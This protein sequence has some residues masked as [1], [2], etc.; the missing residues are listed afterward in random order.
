MP[1]LGRRG[2]RT[3]RSRTSRCVA[4]VSSSPPSLSRSRRR[5]ACL[6]PSAT[7]LSSPRDAT[8]ADAHAVLAPD[9]PQANPDQALPDELAVPPAAPY[10]SVQRTIAELNLVCPRLS[11]SRLP[12]A[13]YAPGSSADSSSGLAAHRVAS[14]LAAQPLAGP[15]ST[16]GPAGAGQPP[17]PAVAAAAAVS[18]RPSSTSAGPSQPPA[19]RQRPPS[20]PA[21]AS[22]AIRK[23]PASAAPPGARQS[24]TPKSAAAGPPRRSSV[25]ARPPQ[26]AQPP[27]PPS[28]K[29]DT[30]PLPRRRPPS[31]RA[32]ARQRPC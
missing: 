28:L 24:A 22:P 3:R 32:Q 12:L 5:P 25:H 4:R 11:L 23:P 7:R 20:Q 31:A 14:Q 1:T 6:P 29:P 15:S 16:Q 17:S 30:R 19:S 9:A 13:S 27:P 2:S 18:G 26:S 8:R 10:R 21:S